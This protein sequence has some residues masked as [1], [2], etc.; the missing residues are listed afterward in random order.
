[1]QTSTALAAAQ[2]ELSVAEQQWLDLEIRR[3]EIEND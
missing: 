1:M 2:S 3:E